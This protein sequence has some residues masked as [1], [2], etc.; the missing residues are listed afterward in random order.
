MKKLIALIVLLALPVMAAEPAKP[1]VKN[2]PAPVPVQAPAKKAEWTYSKGEFSTESFYTARFSGSFNEPEQAIGVGV[3]YAL[4]RN[5]VASVRAVSY[6]D[7]PQLVSEVS[8]RLTAR[9]PL[10]FISNK[11]APYAFI[12]GGGN[13]QTGVGFGGAG[14]G[15]EW[16][17]YWKNVGLFAESDLRLDTEWVTSIGL[18]GGLRLN[19]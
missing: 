18:S 2:P 13:I 12:E 17:P 16:R 1:P 4:T 5:L 10:S 11:L 9:A 7:V 14:G 19:F 3:G 15:I 6:N 8:G